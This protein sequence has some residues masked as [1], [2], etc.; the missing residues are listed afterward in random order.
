M[1]PFLG[2]FEENP[3]VA[4]MTVEPNPYAA[5][6]VVPDIPVAPWKPALRRAGLCLGVSLCLGAL[7]MAALE[8][9][10]FPSVIG[11]VGFSVVAL[12]SCFGAWFAGAAVFRVARERP[13]RAGL[14]AFAGLC[15]FGVHGLMTFFGAVVALLSS[16][17]G[18]GRQLRRFGKVL[19][20]RL[21]PGSTP[22]WSGGFVAFD[23]PDEVRSPLAAQWRE[24]ARTEHASVGAFALL[25]MDLLALGAPPDLLSSA[26][27]DGLDEI[28]HAQACLALAAAID[29]GNSRPAPFEESRRARSLP[30]RRTLALARLAVDSLVDGVLHEGVSARVLGRLARLTEVFE[31]RETV[32]QLAADEGRHAAHAWHVVVWCAREGG[33]PVL[34]ALRGALAALPRSMRSTLPALAQDGSWQRWGIPG[35]ALESAEWDAARASAVRRVEALVAARD[36]EARAA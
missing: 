29:G 7:T 33:D 12:S 31:I 14:I 28:R 23:V 16:G 13:P 3:E 17:G 22:D 6:M 15:L 18:R 32:A 8:A 9:L 27:R 35:R 2:A 11:G 30:R 10:H 36:A 21:V 5:P 24:N 19:L 4:A 1:N 26:H 25:T 34:Y 20:P